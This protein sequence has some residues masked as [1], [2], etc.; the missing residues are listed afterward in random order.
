MPAH[1]ITRIAAQARRAAA[2]AAGILIGIPIRA[3][4]SALTTAGRLFLSALK[5]TSGLGFY[6]CLETEGETQI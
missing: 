3:G 5:D 1:V 4:G 6:I 2:A